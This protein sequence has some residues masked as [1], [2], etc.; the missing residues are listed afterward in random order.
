VTVTS[1]DSRRAG[2]CEWAD[3]SA[4]AAHRAAAW[5]FC[6]E[7]HEEHLRLDQEG[8]IAQPQEPRAALTDLLSAADWQAFHRLYRAGCS[9]LEIGLGL[10][11]TADTCCALRRRLDLLPGPIARRFVLAPPSRG[12]VQDETALASLGG[13][14]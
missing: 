7:H 14:A 1:L 4:P 5:E 11:I 13:A 8:G 3:C 12:P 6:A 10:R 9:D 2:R